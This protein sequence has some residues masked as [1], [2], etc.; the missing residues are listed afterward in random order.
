MLLYECV[1]YIFWEMPVSFH[2]FSIYD[3]WKLR[4]L[5]GNKNLWFFLGMIDAIRCLLHLQNSTVFIKFNVINLKIPHNNFLYYKF[6]YSKFFIYTRPKCNSY[7][8]SLCIDV[9]M[10]LI[11]CFEFEINA[12]CKDQVITSVGNITH[13][14]L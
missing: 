4:Y 13:L 11:I 1:E 9:L 3:W 12:L 6:C 8:Y 7:L 10:V 5:L 14:G 2:K